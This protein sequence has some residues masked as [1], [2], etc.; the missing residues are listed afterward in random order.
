[1]AR[2]GGRRRSVGERSIS[3]VLSM[4][5][6]RLQS[7]CVITVARMVYG[8]TGARTH[9]GVPHCSRSL[10]HTRTARDA[11]SL[12]EGAS[13]LPG[14]V[15][16][17]PVGVD[18]RART[19][20]E[21]HRWALANR[22]R[23]SGTL[24]LLNSR[25]ATDGCAGLN[26]GLRGWRRGRWLSRKVV[27]CVVSCRSNS[28]DLN[29]LI[30][31]GK[32]RGGRGWRGAGRRRVSQ[33]VKLLITAWLRLLVVMLITWRREGERGGSVEHTGIHTFTSPP[34]VRCQ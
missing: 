24:A 14:G 7:V 3:L 4:G 31:Q 32:R 34:E 11:T 33:G 20:R 13:R 22:T 12:G 1:M 19:H 21:A 10:A 26:G 15:F 27:R 18:S 9:T 29:G 25:A 16:E 28:L 30:H 5:L 17:T 8:G 23:C 2:G 6:Q